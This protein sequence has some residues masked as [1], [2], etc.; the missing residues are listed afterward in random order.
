MTGRCR[1]TAAV[2]SGW[3]LVFSAGWAAWAFSV[4]PLK[5]DGL[6]AWV[7]GFADDPVVAGRFTV[8]A[9]HDAGRFAYA[10]GGPLT[11]HYDTLMPTAWYLRPLD[12]VGGR[13]LNR[14]DDF[15]FS[16]RFRIRSE[17]FF[18]DP[19]G[20]AQIAW[21]LVNSETTGEDRAGGSAGPYAFDCVTFDYFPN[22]TAWG[23]PTLGVSAIHGDDG[24]G[25]FSNIDFAFGVETDLSIA[26]GDAVPTLD[27]IYLAE[28]AYDGVEQVATLTLRE[29]PS[30]ALLS[31]NTQGQG[32]YGGYDADPTTVQTPILIDNGFH[33]DSFALTAWQDTYSPFG[34]SVIADVEFFE[35]S[36]QAPPIP[37][38]DVN[39]DRVV[40]GRDL[41]AFVDL[42]FAATPDPDLV[43]RGDFTGDG[44]LDA[45]D[46]GPFVA[47]LLGP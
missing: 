44:A 24:A 2:A 26:A 33:V 23:G 8:P 6:I 29:W 19:W 36:F 17:G 15:T 39:V 5:A 31:I 30:L 7:E 35:V 37:L 20:F 3:W 10:A 22:V 42:L 43:V 27:T 38:G 21:G 45:A 25:F 32:G 46:V 28:V 13:R 9:G 14:Y 41:A 12:A 11:V 47:A 16:V 4:A 1:V 40:D 18:A 34:S